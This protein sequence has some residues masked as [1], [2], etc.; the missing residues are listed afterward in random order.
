[1]TATE[2]VILVDANNHE[3]GTAEKMAAH[4]QNLLHRAFSVFIFRDAQGLELLLQ[5]RAL[6]KYH[7]PGLW[8][9]TCC[10]HPR[11]GEAMLAAGARRLQEEMGLTGVSLQDKGWFHYNAHF[12]NGLSENEIDHVLVGKIGADLDF[13]PNPDEVADTRWVTLPALEAEM[14]ANPERFTPW[15]K[16]ALRLAMG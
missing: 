7:S 8:T 3:I 4:Q 6:S 9:N 13:T 11:Q 14:A 15:L 2:Y 5:K 10:S 16:A 12:E 1:M